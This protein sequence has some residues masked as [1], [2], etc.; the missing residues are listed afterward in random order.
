MK[1]LEELEKQ[2]NKMKKYVEKVDAFT[3]RFKFRK[4]KKQRAQLTG[5]PITIQLPIRDDLLLKR[6]SEDNDCPR[7]ILAQ[8]IIEVFLRNF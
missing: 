3:K 8:N 4:I 7:S 6:L 5:D 1:L 2:E